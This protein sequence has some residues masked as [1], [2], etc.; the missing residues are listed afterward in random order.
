MYPQCAQIFIII[1]IIV[2]VGAIAYG[3]VALIFKRNLLN[4]IGL[5]LILINFVSS[6]V[7][8]AMSMSMS[9]RVPCANAQQ[10]TTLHYTTL[11]TFECVNKIIKHRIQLMVVWLS[12]GKSHKLQIYLLLC[13]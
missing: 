13:I 7:L 6:H 4:E 9:V 5:H 12:W 2:N 11:Q 10:L 8:W 1:I 3:S